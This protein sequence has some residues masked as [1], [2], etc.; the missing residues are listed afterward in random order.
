MCQNLIADL[1][2]FLETRGIQ[3]RP[4]Q[5]CTKVIVGR[6]EL[7]CLAVILHGAFIIGNT[8]FYTLVGRKTVSSLSIQLY[9]IP[10]VSALGGVLLLGEAVTLYLVLGGSAL[11]VAVALATGTGATH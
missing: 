1:A 9:L 3:Q 2:S 5:V 7:N 6:R 11:L 4:R 8:I 10:L